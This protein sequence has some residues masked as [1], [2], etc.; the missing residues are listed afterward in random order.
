MSFCAPARSGRNDSCFDADELEVLAHAWNGTTAG[1]R[2]P[3]SI[4][5]PDTS[6]EARRLALHGAL[7]ARFYSHCSNRENCWLDNRELNESL[8]RLSPVMYKIVHSSILKPKATPG[9]QDWLSTTEIDNVMIQYEALF[10]GFKYIG[11]FPSD[12]FQIKPDAF[13]KHALHPR[14]NRSVS[15]GTSKKRRVSRARNRTI[16]SALP[17][18]PD[19]YGGRPE[20]ALVFN[21]DS[22]TQPGS[23]WVAVTFSFNKSS[24]LIVEYFDPT[25]RP[26]NR[27]IKLF[28]SSPMFSTAIHVTNTY[29]HQKGDSECGVYSLYFILERLMGQSF[30]D[31][32][33]KRI[34]DSSMNRFRAFL[35]RPYSAEFTLVK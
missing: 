12:Y 15:G 34:P 28:L 2:E 21:L 30:Q 19:S 9:P 29:A 23:H 14:Y 5:T 16:S 17:Q 25:G 1:Q 6:D 22:S 13:P 18:D 35:F 7:R 20:S 33:R 24:R 8:H 26:P 31:L 27:N 3:I 11:C 4:P 32:S 10:P